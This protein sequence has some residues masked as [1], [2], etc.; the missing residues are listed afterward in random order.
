MMKLAL[1][2]IYSLALIAPPAVSASQTPVTSNQPR[3]RN[4]YRFAASSDS[5]KLEREINEIAKEGFRIEFLSDSLLGSQVGVMLSRLAAQ[6]DGNAT[7]DHALFEYKVL[8]ANKISTI[9]KELEDAATQGYE[10][11]G[12]TANASIMPFTVSETIAVME[13]ESGQTKQKYE[14]RFLTANREE[15]LQKE[16]DASVSEGF[17]PAAMSVNRDNNAA[18]IMFG[19]PA[20]RYDLVMRRS[21]ENPAAEMGTREYRFL[22]TKKVSDLEKEMN[23]LAADGFR[24]YMTTVGVV[25]LMARGIKD[26]PGRRYEYQLLF[27][28]RTGTL[29]KELTEAGNRGFVFRGSSGL[30]VVMEIDSSEQARPER[31]YKLL[32]ATQV[33]T[34]RKELDESLAAGYQPIRLTSFGEFII[35]L[36]R[37]QK[38]P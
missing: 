22:S 33:K 19:A 34:T 35:I 26:R 10:L 7:H 6:S 9:R 38:K 3:A 1:R 24:C 28:R 30:I 16:L 8:G 15:A 12:L 18:S 20:L 14:Y 29:A 13:R 17:H 23:R 11:R 31:D 36:D 4:E 32:A 27:A 21:V 37:V 5:N 2:I 25:A